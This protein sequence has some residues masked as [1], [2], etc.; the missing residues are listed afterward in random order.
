MAKQKIANQWAIVTGASKGLG[1]AYCQE[2]FEKG[3]HVIAV[4]R[5]CEPVGKLA[6]KYPDQKVKLL[7]LDLSKTANV[8][9]LAQETKNENV[10]CLINNAGYGVWGYFKDSDLEQE[11]NMID[12]D[13][14]A[15]HILTKLFVQRFAENGV[16][17]IINVGSLA[18]FTP[19]PVFAS[20][21]AA[22]AYVWSLGVAVNTELKKTKSPVRVITVCPGPLKTDF[23]N[24]SS[25]QSDANYHST[26]KVMSTQKYAHKSLTKA[27]K[28]KKKNYLI[29][30]ATNKF[31]KKLTKYVPQSWVLT[32]VYNYQRK[33][34][35]K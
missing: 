31:V 18:A 12:L 10:T 35:E 15:L 26:V 30:G 19:G 28:V 5:N 34:K 4:A 14:K 21:Y 25:N 27:L 6:K 7:N 16:G 11:L 24:R 2:L 29:T 22:K 23:W 3:Y 9:Q 8:Y 1:Y 17:R 32:S 33:R 20:Y 13:I